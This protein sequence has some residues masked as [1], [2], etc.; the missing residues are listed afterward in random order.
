LIAVS[1][2]PSAPSRRRTHLI[3][4]AFMAAALGLALLRW[5]QCTRE[6]PAA[7]LELG[8]TH[9]ITWDPATGTMVRTG[10]DPYAWV[11]LPAG[12]IPLR[13]ASLTCTSRRPESDWGFYIYP[14]PYYLP[15]EAV[16]EQRVVRAA[17][18]PVSDGYR[19]R[20]T[21]PDSKILRLDLPDDLAK[22][23]VIE[24]LV[25]ETRFAA[26]D[27]W[28]FTGMVL[29]A[30]AALVVLVWPWVGAALRRRPWL[31]AV[32]AAALMLGAVALTLDVQL[33]FNGPA[34]HDDALFVSQANALIDG[35]WLGRFDDLTLSKGPTFSF[36]LAAT[37]RL[38]V[39]LRTAQAVLQVL[40]CAAFV[41]ALRPLL[42]TSGLRLLLL[43][44]LLFEPN[45]FSAATVGRVLRSGI[46]PALTLLTV[47]GLVGLALAADRSRR[48]MLAWAVLAGASA[49]GFWFSREEGV[50][51]A[52][53]AALL[54]LGGAATVVLA[55]RSRDWVRFALLLLP[56]GMVAVG[57][58][59]LR[60]A[61]ARHYGA[62]ITVDVKDGY[63][64]RAYGALVRLTPEREIIGV[65]VTR[66]TRLRAYAVSPALAELRPALEGP[67]C[68][69]WSHFGWED[70]T[71]PAAGTEIRGGWFQ[72]ALRQAAAVT[73]HYRDAATADQYWRAVAREINRACDSGQLRAGPWRKGFFPRWDASLW[74]P[75][76]ASV[77]AGWARAAQITDFYVQPNPSVGSP[78]Q[79][80]PF[81]RVTHEMG[82]TE[83]PRPGVRTFARV[84][85][86][87]L[88]N[89]AGAVASLLAIAATVWL[90]IA[91]ARRRAPWWPLVVVLALAGGAAALVIVVALVDVT[92][93]SALHAMYLAPAT[94]LIVA[95]CV[96]SLRWAWEARP[97][98]LCV[99]SVAKPR[100]NA[101]PT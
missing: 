66:E 34:G 1:D 18:E 42:R 96:L 33:Q 53:S 85:L 81:A 55:R 60:Q 12:T 89:W 67:A 78:L 25:L 52:P 101:N 90:A 75:L 63:F 84:I 83:P 8:Q 6:I 30:A 46:Q 57:T 45:S 29:A 35:H 100:I 9:A 70:S 64:S 4:A 19:L 73:G 88:F 79:Q 3:A 11:K 87:H 5:T 32:V 99:S 14:Y 48:R 80:A 98:I 56:F 7:A 43:A 68:A 20:W 93:F 21:L 28:A 92:S 91:V 82:M 17:V 40:A 2:S 71:D 36:F 54:V 65:P 16:S 10:G 37:G 95:T 15:G 58:W 50:W 39:P 61:N 86:F 41:L 49:T 22:P 97:A 47:A 74:R 72:W 76:R 13:G 27:A 94:P 26:F 23:L 62:P 44:A 59:A 38:G 24:R 77:F 31:E 69:E 51:L